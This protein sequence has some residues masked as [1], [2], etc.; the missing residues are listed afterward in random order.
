MNLASLGCS[1][2]MI[3][4]LKDTLKTYFTLLLR[5]S[6]IWADAEQGCL[7]FCPE[8]STEAKLFMLSQSSVVFCKQANVSPKTTSPFLKFRC[9]WFLTHSL[10]GHLCVSSFSH[11][12][13]DE[14]QPRFSSATHLCVCVCVSG[15]VS[16]LWFI[17]GFWL[18]ASPL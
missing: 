17:A 10:V 13:A 12:C 6:H 2:Q 15:V 14:N 9:L 16:S 18:K 8:E 5:N 3:D 4:I 7:S 1:Q 11:V